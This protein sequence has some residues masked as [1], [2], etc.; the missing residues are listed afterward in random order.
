[1]A[2]TDIVISAILCVMLYRS[3]TEY[4]RWV[5]PLLLCTHGDGLMRHD[6]GVVGLTL[7]LTS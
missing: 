2:G 6:Y 7:S 3:R 1:M 4:A 5:L